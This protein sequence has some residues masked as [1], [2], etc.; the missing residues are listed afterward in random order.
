MKIWKID[1]Y[2]T[3]DRHDRNMQPKNIEKL[4]TIR[5][6][7]EEVWV[8]RQYISLFIYLVY[9]WLVS[10]INKAPAQT[11]GIPRGPCLPCTHLCIGFFLDYENEYGLLCL[12]FHCCIYLDNYAFLKKKLVLIVLQCSF[13]D[14]L[15]V[16]ILVSLP[17]IAISN[18]LNHTLQKSKCDQIE[19]LKEEIKQLKKER[20]LLIEQQKKA[21]Q[22]NQKI[23]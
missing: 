13:D 10:T 15:H 1:N 16:N 23:K 4:R 18:N 3:S 2:L 14:N 12:P 21:R 11:S 20:D 8:A 19:E 22:K 6:P 9:V 7:I 17:S 5:C